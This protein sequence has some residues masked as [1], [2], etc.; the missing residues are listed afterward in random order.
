MQVILY[1][2][3]KR[4]NSTKRPTDAG[5]PYTGNLLE[6]CSIL[7]PSIGFNF[8]STGNGPGAYNYAHIPE[9]NRYYWIDTWTWNAGLWYA[10]MSV[11]ALATWRDDI[12]ASTQYVVRSSARFNGDIVDGLYPG[13]AA[14]VT[15]YDNIESPWNP[16]DLSYMVGIIGK[17]GNGAV[18]YYNMTP[19]QFT[20][21]GQLMMDETYWSESLETVTVAEL[22]TQFNPIQYISSIVAVPFPASGFSISP[23]PFG[24]WDLELSAGLSSGERNFLFYM[25][26]RKHPQASSRGSYLNSAQYTQY[27]CYVPGFGYFPLDPDEVRDVE[28]VAIEVSYD[29]K[30]SKA[31]LYCRKSAG[32]AILYTSSAV[33]GATVQ[34]AQIGL[35]QTAE[36]EA[37]LGFVSAISKAFQGDFLGATSAINDATQAT[38]P[39]LATQG[40]NGSLSDFWQ[41]PQIIST[42]RPVVSED[43][44][45]RGRPLCERVQISTLPGYIVVADGDISLPATAEENRA[46]KS[47]MEGGFFYE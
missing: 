29:P 27:N 38:M 41:P 7:K 14:V 15:Q 33:F 24:W 37:G 1:T 8:G 3:S 21:L 42:F 36:L 9:W 28:Q 34:L 47:Y 32:G 39:Q 23:I 46:V 22:K 40:S 30:S 4:E 17:S 12:G 20:Q 19:E 25:P 35:K 18:T 31:R 16:A 45:D 26:L 5:A 10:S 43:N 44:E 11:D 2:F 13:T 6:S